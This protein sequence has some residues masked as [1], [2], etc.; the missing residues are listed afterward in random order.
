MISSC[1]SISISSI[2]C[3][4]Q[5]WRKEKKSIFFCLQA[6][7]TRV[8]AKR[9]LLVSGVG[10]VHWMFELACACMQYPGLSLGWELLAELVWRLWDTGAGRIKGVPGMSWT[11]YDCFCFISSFPPTCPVPIRCQTHSCCRISSELHSHDHWGGSHGVLSPPDL[12]QT[13]EFTLHG[14]S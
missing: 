9:A 10:L 6:L 11:A 4:Y 8:Q 3:A 7:R 14:D 12:S 2:Q 13:S 1:S 5:M